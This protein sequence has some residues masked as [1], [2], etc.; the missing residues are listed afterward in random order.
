MI[1]CEVGALNGMQLIKMLRHG[2][3]TNN[4]TIFVAKVDLFFK[5]TLFI[6]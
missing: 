3:L 1:E 6:Y 2:C 4:H 5:T